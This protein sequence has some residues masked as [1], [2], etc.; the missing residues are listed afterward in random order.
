MLKI[1]NVTGFPGRPSRSHSSKIARKDTTIFFNRC[2]FIE[3]LSLGGQKK[4]VQ[5][6]Q[7]V[8]KDGK[9]IGFSQLSMAKC[10]FLGQNGGNFPNYRLSP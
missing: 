8:K 1:F 7:N 5:G 4:W 3:K 10:R 9:R 6:R 2:N